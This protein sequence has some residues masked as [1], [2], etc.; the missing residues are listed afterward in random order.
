MSN[1]Y[2]VDDYVADLRRITG[3]TDDEDTIFRQL[4]PLSLRLATHE[5]WQ[6]QEYLRRHGEQPFNIWLLHEEADHSLPVFMIAWAP[7]GYSPIHDHGTWA[8]VAGISGHEHNALYRRLDDRKTPDYA[9]I[10]E[11][12]SGLVGPGELMCMK[13]GGI[14]KVE[15]PSDKI[16]LSLHTY[17]MHVNHTVRCM[18]NPADNSTQTFKAEVIE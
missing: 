2:N 10:E 9:A 4:G 3:E 12:K 5:R 18:Y 17:G 8:V 14:H 13:N 11:K 16:T 1:V 15:N 6:G 7:G